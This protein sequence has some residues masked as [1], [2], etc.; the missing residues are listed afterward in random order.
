LQ[1]SSLSLHD[2][3]PSCLLDSLLFR[4][5]SHP[6]Q[7]GLLILDRGSIP[8]RLEEAVVIDPPDQV[9]RGKLHVFEASPGPAA[10]NHLRLE[11]TD[12][13]F[14]QRIVVAVALDRKSVV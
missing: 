6:A 9:Q 5:S 10:V 1:Y 2:A 7:V 14:S 11:K 12:D 13:G 8:N 3:L 4:L